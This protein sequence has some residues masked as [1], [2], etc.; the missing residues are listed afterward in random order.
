M[1]DKS[2]TATV[3]V[4]VVT[5]ILAI[6]PFLI[7]GKAL[8]QRFR[9][10]RGRAADEPILPTSSHSVDNTDAH[11]E[12]QQLHYN[13]VSESIALTA[14]TNLDQSITTH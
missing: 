12:A 4:G 3:A 14:V 11:Y 8:L 7:G 9:R 10:W 1:A 2:M 6:P 13:Y 5:G